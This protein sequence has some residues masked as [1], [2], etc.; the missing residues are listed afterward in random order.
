M[1]TKWRCGPMNPPPERCSECDVVIDLDEPQQCYYTGRG[2]CG[3]CD[4]SCFGPL[5]CEDCAK[6]EQHAK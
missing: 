6:E 1:P 4:K 5:Y 2:N 3:D